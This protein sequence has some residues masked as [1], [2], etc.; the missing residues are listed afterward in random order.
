MVARN[1]AGHSVYFMFTWLRTTTMKVM[2][3]N[4]FSDFG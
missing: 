1:T 4:Y 2:I 3:T